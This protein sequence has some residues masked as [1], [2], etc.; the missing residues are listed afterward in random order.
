MKC[1]SQYIGI[2]LDNYNDYIHKKLDYLKEEKI[3]IDIDKIIFNSRLTYN[4]FKY[5]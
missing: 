4:R 2:N 3:A 1:I 5:I